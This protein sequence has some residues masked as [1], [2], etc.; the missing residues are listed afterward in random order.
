MSI[1]FWDRFLVHLCLD[2]FWLKDES[3]EDSKNIPVQD[4]IAKDIAENYSYQYCTFFSPL[5]PL[6]LAI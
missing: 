5:L 1:Y 2:I 3:L 4:I 6:L